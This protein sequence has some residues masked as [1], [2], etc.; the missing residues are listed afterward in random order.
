LFRNGVV[1]DDPLYWSVPFAGALYQNTE[2]DAFA[3]NNTVPGPQRVTSADVG[4]EDCV[5]TIASTAILLEHEF[6][7]R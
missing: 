4:A 5:L 1:N 7:S 2:S 6:A 3:V